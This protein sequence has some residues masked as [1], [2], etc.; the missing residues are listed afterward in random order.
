[1]IWAEMHFVQNAV[2][3]LGEGTQPIDMVWVVMNFDGGE[4]KPSS[5]DGRLCQQLQ[6]YRSQQVGCA[7]C[8][9]VVEQ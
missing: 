7:V 8:L 4:S 6:G 3:V 9:W 1:M 2:F 5:M